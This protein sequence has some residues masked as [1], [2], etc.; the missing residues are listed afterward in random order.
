MWTYSEFRYV[1]LELG[2]GFEPPVTGDASRL[3]LWAGIGLL[4]LAV[5]AGASLFLRMETGVNEV[6]DQSMAVTILRR[7]S[8]SSTSPARGSAARTSASGRDA[9]TRASAEGQSGHRR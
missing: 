1:E 7:R 8:R 9:R 4:A 6:Y 5:C 3:W 2:G